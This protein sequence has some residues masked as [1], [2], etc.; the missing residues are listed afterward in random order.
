MGRATE[1][2]KNLEIIKGLGDVSSR[3][4]RRRASVGCQILEDFLSNSI[5]QN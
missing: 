4:E 3:E 2:I 1:I 5:G